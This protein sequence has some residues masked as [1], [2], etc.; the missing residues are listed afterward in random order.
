VYAVVLVAVACSAAL[1]QSGPPTDLDSY[2][3]R[4][5]KTFEVPGIAVAIVKDGKVVLAKGYGV[6]K[7]GESAPVDENTLFGIGSNTKAFTAAALATLVD[8]GKISWDDKVY[9]RLPGFAMYDPYVSHE[10]TIRDLLCHRSG[11]GL[12]EG[13]LLFWP[14]T[15]FTREEIV[16][17]LRFLKPASS[18]RTRYAYNN[19]MF[20]TAG[21]II[22]AVT[23]KSW[24]EYIRERILAPLDMKTTNLS[25]AELR[26]GSD[27]AWPHSKM[28]GKLEAIEF[29][30][31]D[32]AAPAGSINSSVAEMGKWIL[33][34]LNRGKFPERE[35]RLFSEK[36][37]RE[38]WSAQ[39]IVPL[40]ERTGPLAGLKANFAAY[41]LGWGLR[42]YHGRKLVGHSGGVAG[43]VTR[44]LLVPEENLGIVVLTNAEEGGAHESVV[45]HIVDHYLGLA[46]TDWIAAFKAADEQ[47]RREADET[48]KKQAASRAAESKSSLPIEKYAGRYTDAWYGVASIRM[49]DGKPV[50][51]LERTPKAVGD[52]E[53]WQ[54]DTFKVRWRD[55]TIEDAFVTFTL[56][57]DGGIDHFTMAAV[58]PLADFSF[59]YQ[60]LYFL[61]EKP[62]SE[63][64]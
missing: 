23:G 37:S 21:Q 27:T 40:A 16:H 25:V 14:R 35:G 48:M 17:R 2:V 10:M 29:M 54:Y 8:E 7:L 3:A 32:N 50:F 49:E 36:Q 19:L 18:F 51:R 42:D 15:T 41:G 22:P 4:A 59:D 24:E 55:R 57:P 60:D 9:E 46:N 28:T 13:D 58:S 1:A 43:F 39:M 53:H 30:N 31:L 5:M 52:L 47:E 38:M 64:K 26:P 12:G 56:K 44:V 63:K 45:F 62:A 34:Q 6:K 33:L 20:I 61:P 11:L